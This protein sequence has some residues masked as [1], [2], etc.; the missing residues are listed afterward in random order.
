[1]PIEFQASMDNS[2][3]SNDLLGEKGRKAAEA[4]VK[5]A[6]FGELKLQRYTRDSALVR[7]WNCYGGQ[8]PNKGKGKDLDP[9]I[10]PERDVKGRPK[11]FYDIRDV[12]KS[13]NDFDRMLFVKIHTDET[14]MNE[15]VDENRRHLNDECR[16][17][18]NATFSSEVT[19]RIV[20]DCYA[21]NFPGDVL[22]LAPKE[23]DSD[24]IPYSIFDIH[25]ALV[26][27]DKLKYPDGRPSP[28]PEDEHT[29]VG[30][31][32]RSA[33]IRESINQQWKTLEEEYKKAVEEC[34]QKEDTK[35]YSAEEA[36]RTIEACYKGCEKTNADKEVLRGVKLPTTKYGCYTIIDIR[37]ECV[38]CDNLF[39]VDTTRKISDAR[40]K[41]DL[42][43]QNAILSCG[44]QRY[45][46]DQAERLVRDCYVESFPGDK[47]I[48]PVKDDDP[49]E[50]RYFISDIVK[51][52]DYYDQKKLVDKYPAE[53]EMQ[54][55]QRN[56]ITE[57]DQ[58][59]TDIQKEHEIGTTEQEIDN[60]SGFIIH[61]HFIITSA[62]VV[63]DS[64]SVYIY[65]KSIQP[66]KC[67]VIY[68]DTN[69]CIDLALLYCKAG[70]NINE[71]KLQPLQLSDETLLQGM[72]IFSFGY[73]FF[74]LGKRAL[75]AT[76]F[77]SG[78]EEP[79]GQG[80]IPPLTL[81]N[82]PLNNGNSGGPLLRSV[83]NKVEV[84]GV[85]KQKHVKD[86]L[87]AAELE[88]IG[89]IEESFQTSSITGLR[90]KLMNRKME[91]ADQVRQ[92]GEKPDPFQT[93]LNLLTLKLHAAL[94][95]HTQ[96]VS[97]KAVS[98]KTLRKF[99]R[100]AACRCDEKHKGELLRL[101]V[102]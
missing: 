86:I 45:S 8:L 56:Q 52:V 33:L 97:S 22:T 81:L 99:L 55:D 68:R 77:V 48:R 78:T 101:S 61:N 39:S 29:Q 1:M 24:P 25:D 37:N 74:H 83:G 66:A 23:D 40:K 17:S 60:G 50:K 95:T 47:A 19:Q 100:E 2:H 80:E 34:R 41:V 54:P 13:L 58:C 26:R 91:G 32:T 70:L 12:Y 28:D 102:E 9:V 11:K 59:R 38:R 96:F 67:D 16:N 57:I 64:R 69:S 82:C 42:E 85:V 94:K 5:V 51:A 76:G 98:N 90:P 21:G 73:P 43:Y 49:P 30:S 84:V 71:H 88:I 53:G 72:S 36:K 35:K 20:R 14:E 87:E 75:L 3:N 65:N 44:Q 62:H 92:E 31:C 63:P 46:R 6:I 18:P 93:P 27:N 15:R 79:Y 89:K 10:L 7:L 4:C